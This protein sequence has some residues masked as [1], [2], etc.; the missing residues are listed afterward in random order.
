MEPWDNVL[1]I[2]SMLLAGKLLTPIFRNNSISRLQKK[3]TELNN[4]TR[5]E[6]YKKVPLMDNSRKMACTKSAEYVEKLKEITSNIRGDM[7]DECADEEGV[8][9]KMNLKVVSYI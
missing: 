4:E 1:S 3:Q 7:F 6:L 5:S 2:H 8:E 9:A